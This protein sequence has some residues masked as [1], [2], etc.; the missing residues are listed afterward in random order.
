MGDAII[1]MR[2]GIKDPIASLEITTEP[3][4]TRYVVGEQLN[5]T[6]IEVTAIYKNGNRVNVT[7]ACTFSPANG[8]ALTSANKTVAISWKFGRKI[9]TAAQ[10]LD[11][12]SM[13]EF[14]EK[15]TD[16]EVVSMITAAR[17]GQYKLSDYWKVGDKRTITLGTIEG[18][19]GAAAVQ[20]AQVD[21][22]ITEFGAKTLQNGTACLL[23]WDFAS[24]PI[25]V[26]MRTTDTNSGGY[27]SSLIASWLD[28]KVFTAL[29]A[30]LKNVS[31]SFYA[32]TSA[33]SGSSTVNN[34]IHNLC[35][36]TEKEIFGTSYRSPAEGN[37]NTYITY[38]KTE[39]NRK[40]EGSYWLATTYYES[41]D[42]YGNSRYMC[43]VQ[44]NY[45]GTSL[46]AGLASNYLG[47]APYGCI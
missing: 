25:A 41:G 21:I 2:G 44:S 22:V 36:R 6:G 19:G 10:L 29:P 3:T 30:W 40:K 5:L 24:I 18:V 42:T 17:N 4:K 16:A 39:A 14:W 9:Y 27:E 8:T 45:Y 20:N 35:L 38:Y 1:M 12:V 34:K 31:K 33:G 37:A 46:T 28:S 43:Y 13:S 32:K 26:P 23:Q 47:V 7:N 15:G 11:V